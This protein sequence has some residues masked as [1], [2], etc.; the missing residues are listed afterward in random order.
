[1]REVEGV[2]VYRRVAMAPP[3]FRRTGDYCG[4]ILIWKREKIV[5]RGIREPSAA[6]PATDPPSGAHP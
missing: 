1:M 4:V 2:E 5:G 6:A 3:Q